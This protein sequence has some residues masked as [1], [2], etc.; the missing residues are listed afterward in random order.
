[1][2]VSSIVECTLRRVVCEGTELERVVRRLAE[3]FG[4]GEESDCFFE[5]LVFIPHND[6]GNM[7]VVHRESVVGI[8]YTAEKD[9]CELKYF[10]APVVLKNPIEGS[11]DVVTVT[12][13]TAS[14]NV[15]RTLLKTGFV[16]KAD[17][18]KKGLRFKTRIQSQEIIISRP[19]NASLIEERVYQDGIASWDSLAGPLPFGQN[20]LLEIR[21]NVLGTFTPEEIVN[22]LHDLA[23]QLVA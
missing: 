19:Y 2:T 15:R 1:M 8:E 12:S 11:V 22:G 14:T 17:H 23:N 4:Q 20:Y 6:A 10:G 5:R 7:N 16:V 3:L 21:Q 18:A 9:F 13:V